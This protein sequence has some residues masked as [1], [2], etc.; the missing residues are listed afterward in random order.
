MEQGIK[1]IIASFVMCCLV[2]C[3]RAEEGLIG[4]VVKVADGDTITVLD[5]S[6]TQHKI[7][8][9]GIDAPEK[10]QAFGKVSRQYRAG[11]VAGREVRVTWQ[12]RDRYQRILGTVFV[13]GKDANLEMLKAGLAWHYKKYDSTP[14]YAQ[15]E[16][17]AR[18]AQRGLW[19]DKSPIEPESFRKAKCE[20]VKYDQE[21][22]SNEIR[23]HKP[24][25]CSPL[26]QCCLR[27]WKHDG[28]SCADGQSH[29]CVRLR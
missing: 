20:K 19:Q 4:R 8:L 15:A 6:K 21:S 9:Q 27:G 26:G 23:T 7:R 16:A 17:A 2:A 29:R 1:A 24:R 10:G 11:M 22:R 25:R 18:A 28:R 3:S 13:D 12:K 14:G 5:S